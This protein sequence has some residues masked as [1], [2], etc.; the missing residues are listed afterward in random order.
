LY[1][2]LSWVLHA[3]PSHPPWLNHRNNIW[4]SSLLQPPSISSLLKS[5]CSP[6]PRVLIH[7]LCS[8]LSVTGQFSHENLYLDIYLFT[9]SNPTR[10]FYSSRGLLGCDAVQCCGWQHGPLK[11]WYPTTTLQGIITQM[12]LT[13][14]FTATK[15]SKLAS[16]I[17]Y[18][19]VYFFPWLLLT[20]ADQVQHLLDS[21]PLVCND[22][23]HCSFSSSGLTI[24]LCNQRLDLLNKYLTPSVSLRINYV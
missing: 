2:F 5:N 7:N 16:R 24:L 8:S 20:S 9:Y 15:A 3:L 17:S 11:R 1:A 23:Q 12:T 14:I 21:L 6:Q 10:I 13:W 19:Y 4:C 22:V 18:L